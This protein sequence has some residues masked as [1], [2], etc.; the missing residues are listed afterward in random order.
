MPVTWIHDLSKQQV[1]GLAGQLGLP[2][3]GTLDELRKRVKEKWAF[4]HPYLSSPTAAKS[5]MASG[6]LPLS[7]STVNKRLHPTR[8]HSRLLRARS[9]LLEGRVKGGGTGDAEVTG[10]RGR[11]RRGGV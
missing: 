10:G 1:E 3:D 4:I 5:T 6:A 9:L 11:G 8:V 2:I 7:Q